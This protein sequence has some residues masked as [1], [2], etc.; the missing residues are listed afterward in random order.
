MTEANA[1]QMD[2]SNR[3]VEILVGDSGNVLSRLEAQSVQCCVTSPPYWGL[4]DYDHAEQIGAEASPDEY[5]ENLVRIF[6]Q[7]RRVLRDDGTL[8]LTSA[9][10]TRAT[11][12][13]EGAGPTRKSATPKG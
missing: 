13:P 6:R 10:A 2:S 9:T 12:A 1:P 3:D 5:V 4:R 8:W 7:V 11:A